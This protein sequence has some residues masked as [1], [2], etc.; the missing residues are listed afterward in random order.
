MLIVG[1]EV[2][3]FAMQDVRATCVASIVGVY[4]EPALQHGEIIRVGHVPAQETASCLIKRTAQEGLDK[5]V[6]ERRVGFRLRYCA[7]RRDGAGAGPVKHLKESISG[8]FRLRRRPLIIAPELREDL[9][10]ATG[11]AEDPAILR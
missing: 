6:Q 7:E 3:V 10:H 8:T 4:I 11:K 1:S 9:H 5:D 2:V